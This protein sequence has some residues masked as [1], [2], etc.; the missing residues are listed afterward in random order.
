MK[1]CPY[2]GF[3]SDSMDLYFDHIYFDERHNYFYYKKLK[4]REYN[5]KLYL[6]SKKDAYQTSICDSND[7]IS[8]TFEISEPESESDSCSDIDNNNNNSSRLINN[9]DS[10]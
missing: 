6:Q 9:N 8:S 10:S 1:E 7:S 5:H 4:Q 3:A 2:C